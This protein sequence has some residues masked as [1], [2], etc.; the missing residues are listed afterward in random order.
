[1]TIKNKEPSTYP[2]HLDQIGSRDDIEAVGLL[3]S[4]SSALDV[5]FHVLK[6]LMVFLLV[7]F[8]FSNIFW[9]P[10]GY[11]A[12][13]SRFGKIVGKNTASIC[14][15]GGPYLAF[16]FPVDH[17]VRIPTTIQKISLYNAFWSEQ[18]M[19]EPAIDDRPKTDDLR[20]GIHGSLVTADK[21]IVQGIWV[22]HYKLNVG[23]QAATNGSPVSDFICNVGS[24]Q[25]A[26]DIIRRIAQ[27][28][29]VRVVSQT[30][31]ADFVAGQIDNHQIK[32]IINNHLKQLRTGLTISSVSANQYTVPK[33][34][35]PDFEAVTQAESQKALDIEKASRHRA[36]TLNELAGSQWQTLLEAVNRHEKASRN[37]DQTEDKAAFEAATKIFMEETNRG[38]I[39]QILDEARAE[40]TAAIQQARSSATRFK[41]LL[42][43]FE[44]N[45]GILENQLVKDTLRE[46]WS[47]ISVDA[48]YIPKGQK[49][50]LDLGQPDL[51]S[52]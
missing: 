29:I 43:S 13:Q 40:K 37:F 12:V 50:F 35:E 39:K 47:D 31:V 51:L 2:F 22:I 41:K 10:E 32:K 4:L 30:T 14:P 44:K 5:G 42:P 52:R 28:A 26:G 20:P 23:N 1:M 18:E 45:A 3:D 21:N 9:V 25:H 11:V 16:P 46:I 8:L 6:T 34:L 15:P 49:L 17:I 19:N 38:S 27:A 48:L 24:M 36:S 7:V 33:A